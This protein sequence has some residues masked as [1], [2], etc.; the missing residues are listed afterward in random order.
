MNYKLENI[1]RKEDVTNPQGIITLMI[2]KIVN[3]PKFTIECCDADCH[4]FVFD[5]IDLSEKIR[6]YKNF[7]PRT[8]RSK[9][10]YEWL[11]S[12]YEM[13]GDGYKIFE[14]EFVQKMESE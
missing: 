4:K 2:R 5:I 14:V 12:K 13:V 3:D 6:M 7:P 10:E 1:I 11:K 9:K 8:P